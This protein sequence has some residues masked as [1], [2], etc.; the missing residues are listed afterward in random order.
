MGVVVIVTSGRRE[1]GTTESS[2][3]TEDTHDGSADKRRTH[4][5]FSLPFL[6]FASTTSDERLPRLAMPSLFIDSTRIM[7]GE[8]EWFITTWQSPLGLSLRLEKTF[9]KIL[10]RR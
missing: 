9:R 2:G 10:A 6:N 3:K 7:L 1:A 5:N 4:A 8:S